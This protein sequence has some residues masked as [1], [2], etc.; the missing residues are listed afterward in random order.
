MIEEWQCINNYMENASGCVEMLQKIIN[1]KE[2]NTVARISMILWTIWWKRNQKC[3]NDQILPAFIVV[4]RAMDALHDWKYRKIKQQNRRTAATDAAD[5][6]WQKPLNTDFKCNTDASCYAEFNYYC[7]GACIRDKNGSF[8]QAYMNKLEGSPTI[9][10][11]EGKSLLDVLEWL[12]ASGTLAMPITIETDCLQVVQTLQS[13]Q[14]NYTEFG[15]IIDRCRSIINLYENCRVSYVRRQANR[16]AH[17]LAKA[18]RFIASPQILNTCP[19]CIESI[20]I[21]EMN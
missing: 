20:I 17:E 12:H 21:N 2:P 11:A 8:V 9:A 18:S 13:K 10:E 6:A 4:Q 14:K 5:F 16:V 1:E 19:P 15:A 7:I 3:W